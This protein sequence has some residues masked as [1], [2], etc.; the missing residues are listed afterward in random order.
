MWGVCVGAVTGAAAWGWRRRRVVAAKVGCNELQWWLGAAL[1]LVMPCHGWVSSSPGIAGGVC[2]VCLCGRVVNRLVRDPVYFC[3]K[4]EAYFSRLRCHPVPS[5]CAPQPL[6]FLGRLS[7][8]TQPSGWCEVL[9]LPAGLRQ[10]GSLIL[11][12]VL[13][14]GRGVCVCV[15][16]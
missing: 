15:C 1:Q 4:A 7:R 12:Q 10:T 8:F 14:S 2:R 9:A 16:V 3:L 13:A 11:S 5:S 6:L